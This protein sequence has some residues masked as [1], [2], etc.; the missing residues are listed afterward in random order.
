M[1]FEILSDFNSMYEGLIIK[2]R[3]SPFPFT[4][5]GWTKLLMLKNHLDL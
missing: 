4:R 1:N 2:Y 5:V 3:V